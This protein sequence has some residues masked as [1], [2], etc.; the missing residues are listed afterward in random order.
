MNHTNPAS[1]GP[2]SVADRL[3]TT[4]AIALVA[5]LR[6]LDGVLDDPAAL[7]EADRARIDRLLVEH[8]ELTERLSAVIAEQAPYLRARL[9]ELQ[10]RRTAV[11]PD[12]S[13]GGGMVNSLISLRSVIDRTAG[14]DVASFARQVRDRSVANVARSRTKLTERGAS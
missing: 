4:R 13:D 2:R 7:S 9:D 11:G 12:T 10:E 1:S 14:G 5:E 8:N 6:Q 3:D